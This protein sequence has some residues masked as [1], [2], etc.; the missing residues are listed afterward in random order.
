MRVALLALAFAL[1]P[2][3]LAS[4]GHDAVGCAGCHST[5]VAKG[6]ALFALPPNTKLVDPRT[7]KPNLTLSALCLSCH[8]DPEQGGSGAA[9]ISGHFNHP[10]SVAKP[11]PKLARVPAELLREGRFECVGCHDPHPSNPN[12]RYLRIAVSRTPTLSELC[13]V[14][15]PRKADPSAPATR[16]FSS[17]DERAARPA[18]PAP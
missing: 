11:N 15:H 12:Y 5:H 9:P 18:A 16:L 3:A 14:C 8:A 17:M 10:F 6:A 13:G 4:G 7:G 2:A 1:P